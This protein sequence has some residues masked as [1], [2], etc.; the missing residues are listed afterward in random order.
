MDDELFDFFAPEEEGA[1]ISQYGSGEND[2]VAFGEMCLKAIEAA[3][4]MSGG[5][6]V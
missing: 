2:L 5:G 1:P 3:R 6:D 4:A